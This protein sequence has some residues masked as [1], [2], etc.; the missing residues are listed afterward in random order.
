MVLGAV[1]LGVMLIS[2]GCGTS[3]T[4]ASGVTEMRVVHVAPQ[5]QQPLEML[6]DNKSVFSSI[7]Y[8]VPTAFTT[9]TAIN[10]DVKVNLS[11]TNLFDSPTEPFVKGTSYTFLITNSQSAGVNLQGTKMADDHTVADKG[12]FKIRVV[13]GSPSA[14]AV[15][16]Y[17]VAPSTDFNVVPPVK[18]T[19]AGLASNAPSAYQTLASGA[20]DIYITPAGDQSCLLPLPASSRTCLINLDG[21]NNTA[22]PGFQAGQNRTLIMLNQVPVVAG[23]GLYTTLPFLADLN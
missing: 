11:G 23:G 21:R 16:V 8:G 20:Y 12:M 4:S 9:V 22:A 19:L 13:N 18:A 10:H 2:V 1:A 3:S 5:E 15:D 17:V 7:A 14:G 6:I